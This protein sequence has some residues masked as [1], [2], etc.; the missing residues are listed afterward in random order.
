MKKMI[1]VSLLILLSIQ[2]IYASQTPQGLASDP[3]IKIVNYDPN[4]VV[5][6]QGQH[7]VDTA[8]EFDKEESILLVESGDSTAWLTEI[9]KNVPYMLY[10]KPSLP[11]SDTNM[12]VVTTER[13]YQFHLMT[14][15]DKQNDKDVAYLVVFKYPEKEKRK[16]EQQAI[17]LQRSLL[18]SMPLSPLQWNYNYSF[19]GS[20]LIAPIQAVDN[21]KFTVFKFSDNTT[22][23]AIFSVDSHG[24]ESM[25]NFRVDGDYLFIQGIYRQFT[26][27]N[28]EDVTTLYND[29]YRVR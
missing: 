5:T 28:G 14:S 2:D 24:N 7:Q 25:V 19:Y 16:L 1:L 27:R 17:N 6:L 29:N 9:N 23:P 18:G 12:I 11:A 3:R 10:L 21:G 20:K 4:N 8:I 15:L 26:L 22:I 13:R